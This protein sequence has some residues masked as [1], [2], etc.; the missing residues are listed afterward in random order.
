M[1]E[2]YLICLCVNNFRCYACSFSSADADQSCLTITNQTHTVACPYTYCTIVRQEFLDPEGVVASFTRGCEERPAY[3]NHEVEDFNFRTFFRAC[4]S[5]LCNIG[6]GIQ[7]V[8]GGV[9]SPR[10]EYNGE[11]LLVPGTGLPSH[12]GH[13]KAASSILLLSVILAYLF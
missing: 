10:P 7:S 13:V 6:N 11:N 12:A 9:L 8:V 4:T 1:S 5:S 2:M 3:L